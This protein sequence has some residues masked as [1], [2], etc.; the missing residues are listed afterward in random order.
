MNTPAGVVAILFTD[1]V[2][3]T[4]RIDVLGEDRNEA[5]RRAEFALLEAA[6]NAAGDTNLKNGGD[7][8][9][10]V[11]QSAVQAVRCAIAIQGSF[12]EHNAGVL[13]PERLGVRVGLHAG[14]P[15][16]EHDDV[17]GGT[18][19]V[20]QRLCKAAGGGQILA[21][22]LLR[23]LVG[24]RGGFNFR[25]V[26]DMQL[27]GF[28]DP[29]PACEVLWT[30]EIPL[31]PQLTVMLPNRPGALHAITSRLAQAE[32]RVRGFHASNAGRTASC[33]CSAPHTSGPA[34]C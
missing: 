21:S 33:S 13:E 17:F 26:G 24:T 16:F 8:V 5:L 27:A 34:T 18:V 6:V 15:A 11:F 10:A 20:A 2:S 23:A 25:P 3:S 1:A 9:M 31:V 14:E 7:G 19:V 29:V 28:A 30:P 12:E 22:D 32:V 4:R